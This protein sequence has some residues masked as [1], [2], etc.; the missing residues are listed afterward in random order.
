MK[1][2]SL[3]DAGIGLEKTNFLLESEDEI[4]AKAPHFTR[5]QI[6]VPCNFHYPLLVSFLY[7]N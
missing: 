2:Q 4:L 6:K 1:Y 7:A 3:L 5:E